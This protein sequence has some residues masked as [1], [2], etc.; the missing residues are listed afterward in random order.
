[1][2][3]PFRYSAVCVAVCLSLN[4]AT[5]QAAEVSDDAVGDLSLEKLL[6]LETITV[7]AQ[8]KVQNIQ[9]VPLSVSAFDG[10]QIEKSNIKSGAD[11]LALTPNIGFTED[12]QTGSRGLGISVRGVN[13]LVSG[14]TAFVN[15]IGMFI[16]ATTD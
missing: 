3:Q 2:N 9:E 4:F 10:E 12:G 5:V 6:K 14:E 8:R 7:T 16:K 15:S 1:M 11:Y 13:N